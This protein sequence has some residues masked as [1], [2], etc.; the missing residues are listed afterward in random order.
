MAPGL[1]AQGTSTLAPREWLATVAYRFLHSYRDFH[2]SESLPTPSPP[3]LYANT[4][5]H[6]FD[7]SVT[8]A[9]TQ[10]LDLTLELPI[11]YGSRETYYEHDGV[12][13]HTMRASGIGDLR[14]VGNFWLLDPDC[15]PDHNVSVGLGVKAPTGNDRA[16]D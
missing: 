15:H 10:R 1:G 16:T 5:V 9:V 4:Y 14:L 12:S 2:G 11:Q 8:Y 3:Q 6:T 13:R 7:L